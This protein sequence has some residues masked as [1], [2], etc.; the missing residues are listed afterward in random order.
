MVYAERV[1]ADGAVGGNV[2]GGGDNI[3]LTKAQ[4]IGHGVEDSQGWM[5]GW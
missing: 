1:F 4:V 5:L 3:L 2:V